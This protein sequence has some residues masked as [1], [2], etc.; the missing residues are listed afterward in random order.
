M[1]NKNRDQYPGITVGK[2][3]MFHYSLTL[4][5]GSKAKPPRNEIDK[6][7]MIKNDYFTL[8]SKINETGK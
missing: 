6:A 1:A 7:I 8:K 5:N 2:L 4:S 3:E